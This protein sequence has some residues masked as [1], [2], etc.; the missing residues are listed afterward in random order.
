MALEQE[1]NLRRTNCG[2]EV[3]VG[4]GVEAAS[5]V[6]R[7]EQA[8]GF[9]GVGEKRDLASADAEGQEMRLSTGNSSLRTSKMSRSLIISRQVTHYGTLLWRF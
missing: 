1:V 2:L 4:A 9:D 8:E 3:R 6:D 7:V 5:V